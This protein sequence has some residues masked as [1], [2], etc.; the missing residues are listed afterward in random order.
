MAAAPLTCYL[1]FM[2]RSASVRDFAHFAA[3]GSAEA[4]TEEQRFARAARMPP[5]EGILIGLRL[6]AEL[7]MTPA[8]LVEI[9]ARVDG[10]MEL[11]RRR[12]ALALAR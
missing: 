7:P 3:I 9:D 11:A 10:E 4:E 12:V 2:K 5:G 1:D 6:G 8:L